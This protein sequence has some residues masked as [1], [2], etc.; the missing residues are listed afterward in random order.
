MGQGGKEGEQLGLAVVCHDSGGALWVVVDVNAHVPLQV[1][2]LLL[3]QQG[4]LADQLLH[5]QSWL[6]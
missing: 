5:Q 3:Q 4:L 1:A 2:V 6:S